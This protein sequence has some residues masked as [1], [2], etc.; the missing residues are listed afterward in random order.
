MSPLNDEMKQLLFDYAIQLTSEEQTAEAQKLIST[1]KEASDIYSM[2]RAALKPLDSIERESCPDELFE[3]TI[4][5]IHELEGSSQNQLEQLITTDFS[6]LA[7]GAN[8]VTGGTGV[9]YNVQ[10]NITPDNLIGVTRADVTVTVSWADER[11]SWNG[12]NVHQ[13]TVNSVISQF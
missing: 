3:K 8:A 5:R 10:W 13:V 7:D 4:S 9:T 12:T 11:N 6:S 2:L 1:N